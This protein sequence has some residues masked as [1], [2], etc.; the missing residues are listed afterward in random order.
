MSAPYTLEVGGDRLA[1]S[2]SV[3]PRG[4]G[5]P[6]RLRFDAPNNAATVQLADGEYDVAWQIVGTPG[7]QFVLAVSDK[8]GRQIAVY[9]DAIGRSGPRA[10]IGALVVP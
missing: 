1:Y 5:G 7:D 6:D 10:G 9:S 3:T 8:A 4:G 2:V